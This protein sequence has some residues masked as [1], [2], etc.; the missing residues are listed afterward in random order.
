MFILA[1]DR[2][3]LF[4]WLGVFCGKWGGIFYRHQFFLKRFV[5]ITL[6][7]A[8]NFHAQSLLLPNIGLDIDNG[9]VFLM[10]IENFSNAFI[11]IQYL[12]RQRTCNFWKLI[13][14]TY[15]ESENPQLFQVE[16]VWMR[17]GFIPTI[18][19]YVS[20]LNFLRNEREEI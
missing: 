5:R 3:V 17:V 14:K 1:Q 13:S 18:F 19:S 12:L 16:H 11:I 7:L 4:I 10:L 2:H 8:R 20:S 6:G 15:P 9:D